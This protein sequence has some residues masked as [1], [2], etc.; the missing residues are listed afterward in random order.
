MEKHIHGLQ[1]GHLTDEWRAAAWPNV[2]LCGG[3]RLH[4]WT[5]C[6]DW[7]FVGGLA[8]LLDYLA[9]ACR[10][11]RVCVPILHDDEV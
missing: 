4:G 2:C 8:G 5:K 3:C 11:V 7:Q 10:L 6:G 9:Y 1:I